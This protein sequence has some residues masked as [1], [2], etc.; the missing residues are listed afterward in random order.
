MGK[1]KAMEE[2][3]GL[4]VAST[5]PPEAKLRKIYDRV[6]QIRNKSYE[7]RKSQQEEQREK[8]KP[9]ENVEDVW[10]RGYGNRQQL[11]WLFLG[12][13]RAVGFEAYGCWVSERS[14][15][16]FNPKTM[17]ERKLDANVVLVKVNGK[18]LYFDPGAEFTPFGFLTWSETGVTGLR[19]DKDGG[20][21]IKTPLP[22]AAESR[23]ERKANLQLAET[24]DLE[25]KLKVT[26]TGLEAMYIR[27]AERHGDEVARKKLLEDRLKTQIPVA[28]EADLVNQ[29][30]WS[31]SETPLVAEFEVKIPGWAANAGKRVV[32]PAGIF[33]AVE[34]RIFEHAEIERTHPIYFEYPYEKD[35]DVTITLPAGWQVSSLPP[36]KLQDG[37]VV[38]YNLKAESDKE[39]LHLIRKLT[40]DFLMLDAKYYPALRD[41]FQVVRTADEQQIVLQ[42]GR[43]SASN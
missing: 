24:G 25:G 4:I 28:V 23:I 11:T 38:I 7:V 39:G 42:R 18:D 8:E 34:K 27:L 12:L 29:P 21:W 14:Q 15:Y 40:V 37:H 19:L 22:G 30:D 5:D 26:Y 41:F 33:T 43:A 9:A 20:T 6:Q 16:F 17:Q 36:A 35:D 31:G 1:K 32:L 2:A 13:A 10:K 3:V